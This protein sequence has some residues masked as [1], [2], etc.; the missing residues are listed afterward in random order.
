[1]SSVF[2][3]LICISVN[4]CL[5][6]L[7]VP[8]SQAMSLGYSGDDV[9]KQQKPEGEE[10]AARGRDKAEERKLQEPATERRGREKK[11]WRLKIKRKK[12]GNCNW[13]DW[14]QKRK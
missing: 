11:S 10:R 6:K 2:C 12:R 1:M 3:E 8:K 5:T 14:R 13:Q 9:A 4:M 7:D